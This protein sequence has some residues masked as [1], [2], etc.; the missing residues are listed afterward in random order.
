MILNKAS[1]AAL[2][3]VLCAGASAAEVP[4]LRLMTENS[5][6]LSMLENG[7]VIGSGTDKVVEIM[8]RTG[9]AYAIDLLPWRRAYEYIKTFY[10]HTPAGALASHRAGA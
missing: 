10:A 4:R 6:P 9:T 8:A 3:A 2:L 7:Q 1:V 5:P